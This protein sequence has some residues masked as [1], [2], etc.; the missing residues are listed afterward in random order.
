[1]LQ[2]RFVPGW[3]PR[4][5]FF[6]LKET[7]GTVHK[8]FYALASEQPSRKTVKPLDSRKT[9]LIDTYKHLMENSSMIFFVH[10]NN[11][12]KTEDHHFRFKI[13][14]TGGKLT[15]VRN[16]LFEVYL[17]NSHL[18]DPCGFVKRKEQN[19]KHPL[20]PLLKGP[21]ATITYEDTNPQ[22]VAKLL[23]VLQ[24]AQD[25][26][27]VIG[28]KVEN[29][30]LNVEKINTFKTL[31]TKPE[32]Q[33]QLVSVLQMLSGLGLVRTLENSSNALYLTLKSHNDN[34]KPKEDVESTT[35]A[36][37]KGSK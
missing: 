23:K 32:M 30:V 34:Q 7:I 25:K 24:S 26:L 19:W 18:P 10:Y 4:N 21:T 28:A 11:L 1:M 3:V 20:L 15:K 12:S 27:M 2:L 36:E 13:K 14:Q 31:P 17:R 16:N 35:D 22:Q 6:G 8:R 5:G 29:E 9:F 33:S 37:S